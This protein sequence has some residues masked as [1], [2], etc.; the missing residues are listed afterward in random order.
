MA[1]L[2]LPDPA[3]PTTDTTRASSWRMAA[4]CSAC[5][6]ATIWRMWRLVAPERMSSS[7]E[8]SMDSEVS[9]K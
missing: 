4:F 6:V 5:M 8:S 3:L 2:V 9:T 1:T 7:M